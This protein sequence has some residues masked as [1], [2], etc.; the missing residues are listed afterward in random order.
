[1]N[2][3]RHLEELGCDVVGAGGIGHGAL[4]AGDVALPLLYEPLLLL[5]EQA[6]Q[7]AQRL[8]LLLRQLQVVGCS[9]PHLAVAHRPG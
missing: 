7:L 5:H 3:E 9:A 2:K 8:A 6:P 1:M 4:Q